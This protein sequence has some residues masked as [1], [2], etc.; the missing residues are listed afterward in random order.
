MPSPELSLFR[1][2]KRRSYSKAIIFI[3]ISIIVIYTI[4]WFFLANMV[5]NKVAQQA[6]RY[7][8]HGFDVLCEN[9][10]KTGYPLRIGIT[11]DTVNLQHPMKGFAFSSEKLAAGVAIYTPRWLELTIAPPASIEVPG[12]VPILAKWNSLKLETDVSQPIPDHII[13]TSENFEVGAKAEAGALTD[14]AT[15]QFLRFEAKGLNSDLSVNFNFDKL[16]LPLVIPREHTVLP[17]ISGDV[18]WSLE[19]AVTLLKDDG[20]SDWVER[21]HNHK[22]EL[23]AAHIDFSSGGKV[24]ISGPFAF[25]EDGYLDANFEIAVSDQKELLRTIQTLLPSQSDNLKTVFFAINAMPKNKDGNPVIMLTVNHGEARLG[26]FKI[27]RIDP[28]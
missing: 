1:E 19:N 16:N 12:L 2:Q 25:D 27:G 22:G 11:C 15:G 4:V 28:I 21:L 23:N 3:I 5:E 14:R 18:K 10:H 9:M 26:F 13:L 20:E 6:Q 8:D 7:N 24:T 17:E